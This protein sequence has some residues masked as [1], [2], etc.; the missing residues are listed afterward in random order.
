M[1]NSGVAVVD[2][3]R[4]LE[5]HSFSELGPAFGERQLLQARFGTR[6]FTIQ[7]LH[8]NGHVTVRELDYQ[9][10]E[11]YAAVLESGSFRRYSE[12]PF[13]V[14][15]GTSDGTFAGRVLRNGKSFPAIMKK[16]GVIEEFTSELPNGR[17]YDI[18]E[19]G[20]AVGEM[21]RPNDPTWY[22]AGWQ[23]G[24]YISF[25]PR[26]GW[27]FGGN[28]KV[29]NAG[30][31]Q[32]WE[33]H[34]DPATG[35]KIFSPAIWKDG[36]VTRFQ[37]RENRRWWLPT[38]GFNIHGDY[39]FEE[40]DDDGQGR[41][42]RHTFVILGGTTYRTDELVPPEYKDFLVYPTSINDDGWI[43]GGLLNQQ[44]GETR[45]FVMRPVPEPGSLAALGLGL[46]ALARRRKG[47][48]G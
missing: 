2:Y 8:A 48:Q 25:E 18:N 14:S 44:T 30:M 26:D 15:S 23:D 17:I 32:G 9:T 38:G 20:F 5:L 29:N 36:K 37:R 22:P 28:Y 13:S 10:T 39:A 33:Y 43:A 11:A 31:V 46:A 19:N 35:K 42:N 27:V 3:A 45:A 41:Y 12:Q 7:K 21:D 1:N 24:N 6:H 16:N 4:P 47:P 34:T 40:Y